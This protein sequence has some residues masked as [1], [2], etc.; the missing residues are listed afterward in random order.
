MVHASERH[1]YSMGKLGNPATEWEFWLSNVVCGS[2]GASLPNGS[3]VIRCGI[4]R[5]GTKFNSIFTA[6]VAVKSRHVMPRERYDKSIVGPHECA[7][8]Y[9]L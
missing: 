3:G 6:V 7:M 2:C 5:V 9:A 1:N 4:V 8:F